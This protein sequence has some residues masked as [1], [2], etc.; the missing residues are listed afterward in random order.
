MINATKVSDIFDVRA[1]K[2][3]SMALGISIS[4]GIVIIVYII[5]LLTSLIRDHSINWDWFKN[6]VAFSSFFSQIVN[7]VLFI[8]LI[9]NIV[10]FYFS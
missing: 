9:V 6:I 8:I 2:I 1:D 10:Y 4:V 5:I 7:L 3:S